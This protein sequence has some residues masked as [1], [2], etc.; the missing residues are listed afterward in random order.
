MDVHWA[1]KFASTKKMPRGYMVIDSI[2]K[3]EVI[4]RDLPVAYHPFSIMEYEY[5]DSLFYDFVYVTADSKLENGI[6]K[7]ERFFEDYARKEERNGQYLLN[8]NLVNPIFQSRYMSPIELVRAAE[9]A[10]LNILYERIRGTYFKEQSIDQLVI[11]LPQFYQSSATVKTLV[12]NV[13]LNIALIEEG[14][15]IDMLS[16]LIDVCIKKG[17]VENLIDRVAVEYPQIF[18]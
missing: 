18:D 1:S 6:S 5:Q 9:K 10:K 4:E 13:G 3:I 16:Q 14:A 8:P 11:K 17:I 7:I 12:K 15:A 2:D